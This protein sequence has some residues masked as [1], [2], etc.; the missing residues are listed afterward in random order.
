[1][2][3]KKQ[4]KNKN[5]LLGVCSSIAI[6]KSCEL[7]RLLTKDGFS[8]KV[9]MT[10]KATKLISPILFKE[11]SKNPVYIDMFDLKEENTKHISLSIWTDICVIAPISANTISKIANGICDNLLTTTVCALKDKKIILAPAMN[12][13]MWKSPII[14]ENINK[15]KR[16]KNYIILG[17][18]KGRLLCGIGEGRMVG[19][20]E[21]YKCIKKYL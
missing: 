8:V 21:I 7:I 5:I 11:L 15:L 19:I 10:E 16:F 9:V 3:S 14:Q 17:P 1:M 18:E 4:V 2:I 12:E 13:S 20:E 6:Y